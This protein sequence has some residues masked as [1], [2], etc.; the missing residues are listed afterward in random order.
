MPRNPLLASRQARRTTLG[1][2]AALVAAAA[3][4]ACA[5]AGGDG[6]AS[7][8]A[9]LEIDGVRYSGYGDLRRQP[10]TTGRRLD[11]VVPGCDDTGG[12]GG[13]EP[14]RAASAEEL[15]GVAADRAVLLDGL[16]YVRDGSDLPA[17]AR[18]WFDPVRCAHAGEAELTGTWLG[19]TGSQEPRA[20]GDL[21]PPYRI[22]VAV[23]DGPAT[24][25]GTTVTLRVT[26][27]TQ[28][29]LGRDDV[30]DTL[31]TGGSVTARVRCDD[32]R[33]SVLAVRSTTPAE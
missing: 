9:V 16:L 18:V 15:A 3:L 13:A 21:R 20:D 19:V 29:A 24:Y 25:A 23:A 2:A 11:V 17:A 12:Q 31:W 10:E 7:C 14:D 26:S 30:R 8:A 33:F 4:T 27:D 6:S 5:G 28:P 32:G 22:D 1:L